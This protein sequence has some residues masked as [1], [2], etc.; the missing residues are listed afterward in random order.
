MTCISDSALRALAKTVRDARGVPGL[1]E[2]IDIVCDCA[3]GT[4]TIRR[5]FVRLREASLHAGGSALTQIAQAAAE[6]TMIAIE[7]GEVKSDLAREVR[8]RFTESAIET[9]VLA[10]SRQRTVGRRFATVNEA[11][12][13]QRQFIKLMAPQTEKFV[14][15]LIRHPSGKGL[16]APARMTRRQATANLLFQSVPLPVTP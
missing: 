12:D 6:S 3:D 11:H 14:D 13:W 2:M 16:R 15:S 4:T 10:P 7:R 5:S 9:Y 1:D 8:R